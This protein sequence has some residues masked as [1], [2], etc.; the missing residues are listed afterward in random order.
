[1]TP[2]AQDVLFIWVILAP[3]SVYLWTL[4]FL[5]SSLSLE[6]DEMPWEFRAA[7]R[8][9][10]RKRSKAA[11]PFGIAAQVAF[12]LLVNG[13]VPIILIR[14]HGALSAGAAIVYLVAHLGWLVRTW[15]A[16]HQR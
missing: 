12:I 14:G 6:L 2:D 16:A 1:M 11:H 3:I 7:A 5:G 15:R 8:M 10:G 4:V 9:A 13:L